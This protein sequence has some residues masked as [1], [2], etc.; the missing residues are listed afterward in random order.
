MT[1]QGSFQDT[2]L[3]FTLHRG[4]KLVHHKEEVEGS[5]VL[6]LTERVSE[7]HVILW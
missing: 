6:H 2:P 1:G 7:I 5:S 3:Y 4:G